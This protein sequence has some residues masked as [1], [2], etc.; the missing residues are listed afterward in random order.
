M[1]QSIYNV[2]YVDN[3]ELNMKDGSTLV[4]FGDNVKSWDTTKFL[5]LTAKSVIPTP[6]DIKKGGK[7]IMSKLVHWYIVDPNE[8]VPENKAVLGN[9]IVLMKDEREF[10]IN[11][12]IPKMLEEYNKFRT[13]VTYDHISENTEVTR[14]L[15]EAKVRDLEIIFSVIR[16]FHKE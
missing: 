8:R 9:G 16:E 1:D 13:T 15:K 5:N 10:L 3:T 11:L 2:K 6:N 7:Q 4:T 12:N 14:N